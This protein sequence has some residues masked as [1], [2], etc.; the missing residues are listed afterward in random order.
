MAHFC[1][2]GRSDRRFKQG[3]TRENTMIKIERASAL[4]RLTQAVFPIQKTEEYFG[5]LT[6]PGKRPQQVQ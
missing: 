4:S 5:L 2:E 6:M 1:Y 3:G